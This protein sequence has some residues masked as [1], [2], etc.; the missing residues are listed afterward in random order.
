ML[1]G[2]TV[3]W[4]RDAAAQEAF[5]AIRDGLRAAPQGGE[6]QATLCVRHLLSLC[7]A[8]PWAGQV[9]ARGAVDQADMLTAELADAF[10]KNTWAHRAEARGPEM[11]ALRRAAA[12]LDGSVFGGGSPHQI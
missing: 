4:A 3:C 11:T 2:C 8:D 9:T 5:D 1:G 6:R 7:A 12:F 10:R